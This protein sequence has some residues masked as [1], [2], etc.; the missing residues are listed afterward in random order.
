MTSPTASPSPTSTMG[1]LRMASPA[2]SG[3]RLPT[4][5]SRAPPPKRVK[6]EEDSSRMEVLREQLKLYYARN[7][8]LT[9]RHSLE[10]RVKRLE[11]LL[12]IN[13]RNSF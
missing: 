9:T 6:S 1:T 12:N 3:K 7:K 11:A 5:P 2:S 13:N 4:P 10:E 8:E